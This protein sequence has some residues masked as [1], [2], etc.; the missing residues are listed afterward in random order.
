MSTLDNKKRLFTKSRF[1]LALEC[2]TKLFYA[3]NSNIYA[4]Q[5]KDDPFL[6]ALA[7][8][9]YQVGELAKYLF[10]NNPI[11][12]DISIES[13]DYEVSLSETERKRQT[14]SS[15][16]IAEAAFRYKD[17]FVRTD[18]FTEE[19]EFINIYEVKAK[20]WDETT[21]FIKTKETKKHGQVTSLVQEWSPYLYDI[22]FQKHVVSKANPGKK[23]RAHIILADK[24][25]VATVDGLNQM[26]QIGKDE[27]GRIKITVDPKTSAA[28]LGNIPLKVINVDDVCEWI[29]NN[30]VKVDLEGKWEFEPLIEY[31]AEEFEN[32]KRIWSSCVGK[33]CKSCQ[34]ISNK[35]DDGLKSGFH[36]CWKEST[37]L[38]DQE[39]TS[40]LILELWGGGM[41]ATSLIDNAI[42]QQLYLIK[43]TD[44]TLFAKDSWTPPEGDQ[45][46][47]TKRR[48]VQIDK[49]NLSDYSP[50]LDR[51]GLTELFS[52]LE[53]PYHFIDFE[54][55]MVALPFHKGLTPYEGI[56]FQ[57]S[58]HMMDADGKI[59]HKSQFLSFEK[60]VF[61]NYNFVRAL[62]NDLFNKSGT[63]FRY[64]HHENNFLNHIYIQLLQEKESDVPDKSELLLFIEQ[65]AAPTKKISSQWQP[66]NEMQD[67]HAITIKHFYSL[68]AKGSNSIKDIL[69]AIIK[70]S[71]YIQNKYS[72]PIY[73]TELFKSLN[74]K[75]P[76]TWIQ[77]DKNMNPYKT[78][79]PIFDEK[80]MEMFEID[81]SDLKEVDN[82]GAAMTAYAYLQFSHLS[83]EQRILYRDALLR[84]CELDTFAMAMIWDYWGK[85]VGK[86]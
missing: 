24:T 69:P 61:P 5:K 31:F 43:N 71:D 13:L 42:A 10:S 83:E 35:G 16:V 58:Y 2:P 60:G 67:L 39:L 23:V 84:Y 12:D 62:K 18:I 48:I 33:K 50:Y 46:D 75:E 51:D 47:A 22:A 34:F 86:W 26:F 45:L 37:N 79:P 30:P 44:L 56:A 8:G 6:L 17:F 15:I 59:E 7:E 70:S 53:P 82:G 40:P 3:K 14:K 28:A 41:G 29:Y 65:I 9:G 32:N 68:Y 77:A 21:A 57:Y 81:C 38:S 54:T 66:V 25:S 72:Q 27:N 52:R 36:E 73:G 76:H 63:I 4:D 19:G 85:E 78:L 20:S 80:A 1:K 64:H 11:T 74:F 49:T 55:T